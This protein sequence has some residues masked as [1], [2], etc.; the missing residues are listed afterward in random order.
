MKIK[1][2][3]K[4]FSIGLACLMALCTT[5]SCSKENKK[6]EPTETQEA[7][8]YVINDFSSEEHLYQLLPKSNFGVISFNQDG[9]YILTGDGS[10]KLEPNMRASTPV[11]VKQRL[12]SENFEYNHTDLTQVTKITAQVYNAFDAEIIMQTELEFYDSSKTTQEKT[13]LK[14]NQWNTIT[15]KVYSSLLD[16][17]F[18]K[19]KAMYV[20]YYF[21]SERTDIAPVL[22]LDN[23]SI[24]YTDEVQKPIE[25][26]LDENEFCSFDKNYQAYITYLYGW[27]NYISMVPEMTLCANPKYTLN[28]T[29]CSYKIR[30]LKGSKRWANWYYLRFSHSFCEQANLNKVKEGDRLEFSIYNDGPSDSITVEFLTKVVTESGDKVIIIDYNYGIPSSDPRYVR[31]KMKAYNWNT[32]TIDFSRLEECGK[33]Q[34]FDKYEIEDYNVLGN[35]LRLQ[36]AWGEFIDCEEKTFYIDEMK[37]IKGA[38]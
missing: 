2:I 30:T 7:G 22:Y 16:V 24:S 15:Y 25:V 37:I 14:P 11:H 17:R 3:L 38:E 20:N 12:I 8:T 10:A 35:L 27:G 23:V 31:N 1:K 34:V 28:G 36:F 5:V 19:E 33:K 26:V 29:G 9:E 13:I 21:D 6:L 4:S 18:E 32:F